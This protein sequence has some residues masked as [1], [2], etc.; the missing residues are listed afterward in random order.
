MT[1][2]TFLLSVNLEHANWYND[3][4]D[5]SKEGD[6]VTIDY[7]PTNPIDKT[8]IVCK[9]LSSEPLGYFPSVPS[10]ILSC[11][12]DKEQPFQMEDVIVSLEEKDNGY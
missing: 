8:V 9:T 10:E 6:R 3:A 7:K 11:I 4:F 5:S 1:E 2:T 12:V